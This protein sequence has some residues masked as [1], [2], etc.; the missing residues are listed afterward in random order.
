MS[1]LPS[2]RTAGALETD[3]DE[4]R[5]LELHDGRAGRGARTALVSSGPALAARCAGLRFRSNRSL[6]APPVITLSVC[7]RSLTDDRHPCTSWLS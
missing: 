6:A 4:A 3:L 5:P 7:S 1:C 2:S